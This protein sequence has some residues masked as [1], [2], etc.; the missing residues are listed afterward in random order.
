MSNSIPGLYSAESHHLVL[1]KDKEIIKT[2][3][4]DYEHKRKM[5]ENDDKNE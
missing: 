5:K 2:N 3:H 1:K 4:C